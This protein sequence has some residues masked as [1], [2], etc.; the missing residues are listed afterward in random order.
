[1]PQINGFEYENDEDLNK[2]IYDN[3]LTTDSLN[4]TTTNTGYIR[5]NIFELGLET[6]VTE[7]SVAL[8]YY[9]LNYFN[10]LYGEAV[11]KCIMNSMDDCFVFFGFKETTDEPTYDMVESHAGFMVYEGNLYAT[12]ADGTTQQKV[13]IEGID[14]T[15][16]ENFKINFNRFYIEPLPAIESELGLPMQPTTFPP[17]IRSW[18]LATQLSNYPPQNQVHYIIHYIKNTV[19]SDKIIKFNRF[20]YREVYAD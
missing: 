2:Y 10:P 8:I 20:I 17:I 19:G 9:N 7:S 5:T 14:M 6:G 18:W 1:M 16:V 12:V 13:L 15:R 3:Y 11:W 4:S